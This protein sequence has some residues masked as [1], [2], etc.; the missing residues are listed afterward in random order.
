MAARDRRGVPLIL[1][2]RRVAASVPRG[3]RVVAWLHEV[4][5][6]TSISE[7]ALLA[8]GLS[9]DE[10]RA[11]RLLARGEDAR[12]TSIYL[13]HLE[14]IACAIGPGANIAQ[15]VKRADLA[16]RARD[17]ATRT[18]GWSPPYELSLEMLRGRAGSRRW[19]PSSF[20]TSESRLHRTP[21]A[22]RRRDSSL[23]IGA[24]SWT[25]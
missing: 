20:A 21:S 24:R 8:D 14:L 19:L 13:A 5:A 18:D 25:S 2:I 22:F 23:V 9:D 17:A 12:S 15:T 10:L 11:L 16:D 6:Y 1:H 7:A 4:F 3:A